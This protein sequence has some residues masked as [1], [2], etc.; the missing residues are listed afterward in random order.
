MRK[1][2]TLVA[3]LPLPHLT[4]VPMKARLCRSVIPFPVTLLMDSTR[5]G[6]GSVSPVKLHSSIDKS[7]A[8]KCT[9]VARFCMR[10]TF[11]L[12]SQ[13]YSFSAYNKQFE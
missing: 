4:S 2:L 6:A 9:V 3:T 7:Y 11:E 5:F 12:T 13:K 10:V 8:F 1:N